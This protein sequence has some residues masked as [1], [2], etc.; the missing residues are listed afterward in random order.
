[1]ARVRQLSLTPFGAGGFQ[2][3]GAGWQGTP[4]AT[5]ESVAARDDTTVGV[6]QAAIHFFVN[7]ALGTSQMELS[8]AGYPVWQGQFAPFGAELDTQTTNNNYKF[9][10]K[11]RDTE[12]GLDYFGA[13]YYA[14]SM[15]RWMSPDYQD[16]DEDGVPD[17][18]P[19]ASLTNPQTLNLYGYVENNSLSKRD[20]DGHSSWQDCNGGT[21]QC[22][23]GDFN[24]DKDCSGSAGCLYWSSSAGQWQGTDP[25]APPTDNLSDFAGWAFTGLARVMTAHNGTQFGHGLQQ[26][27]YGYLQG[28]AALIV[29]KLPIR[30]PG[31]GIGRPAVVPDG[32]TEQPSRKGGGTVYVDPANPHNRVRVMPGDPNSPNPAM[33]EPYMKVQVSGRYIDAGGNQVSGDSPEAHI[34]P[35][36]PMEP[37][38]IP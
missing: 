32:W 6:Q 26:M 5:V 24:G 21:Q 19:H 31:T 9:T 38:F 27:G 15:G 25:T 37:P 30:A 23:Q 10:G 20:F 13:R 34:P 3:G 4:T 33:R 16:L 18:A 8:A 11:E 35:E 29:G 14:S 17:A 22:W 12:S 7:D 36:A 28:A 1:M 2:N